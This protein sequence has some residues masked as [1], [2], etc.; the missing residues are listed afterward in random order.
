M[1]R[2]RAMCFVWR[3]IPSGIAAYTASMQCWKQDIPVI[4]CVWQD[5]N[6]CVAL[7]ALLRHVKSRKYFRHMDDR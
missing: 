4:S 5:M 7:H 1:A 6:G 3:C 2:D